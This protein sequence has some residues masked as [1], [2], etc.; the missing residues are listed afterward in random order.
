MEVV[1]FLRVAEGC[2]IYAGNLHAIFI[3]ELC[4]WPVG[5]FWGESKTFLHHSWGKIGDF[6]KVNVTCFIGLSYL[7]SFASR[8]WLP[9]PKKYFFDFELKKPL[10][11]SI[12]DSGSGFFSS[13]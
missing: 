10:P 7:F 2:P 11:E 3:L 13:L 6:G 5:W 9:K 12:G 8:D 4:K 1:L